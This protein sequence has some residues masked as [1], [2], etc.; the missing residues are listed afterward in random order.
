MRWAAAAIVAAWPASAWAEGAA[1]AQAKDA[2]ARERPHTI[3]EVDVGLLTLPV[4]SLCTS[5]VTA[6]L[7]GEA[8]LALGIRNLYRFGPFAAGVGLHYATSLKVEPA[9]GPPEAERQHERAYFVVEGEFRYLPHRSRRLDWWVGAT[10]G[11]VVVNDSWSTLADR[12]PYSEADYIGPRAL[13]LA[14]VGGAAGG[15]TGVDWYFLDN[16]T[17][18]TTLR[19]G[20]WFMPDTRAQTATGDLA[21]LA[22]P[23]LVL[24]LAV[25]LS[26]RIAL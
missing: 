1:A 21:S 4:T 8:S 14:T 18:G 7:T 3:A 12:E 22:G 17:L 24:Q 16:W 5:S 25:T 26:Y 19:A 6:C 2:R 13:T 23:S 15:M 11:V 10:A 9:G 20:G